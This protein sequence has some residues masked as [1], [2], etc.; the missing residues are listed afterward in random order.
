M[1]ARD[2]PLCMQVM[3]ACPSTRLVL[4]KHLYVISYATNL[5]FAAL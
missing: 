1:T 5:V 3:T 2:A 4:I